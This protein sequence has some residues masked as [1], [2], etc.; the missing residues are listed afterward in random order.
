ME[1]KKKI[2]YQKQKTNQEYDKLREKIMECPI[3]GAY[4]LPI[5]CRIKG[6]F[7]KRYIYH[8]FCTKCDTKWDSEIK[9]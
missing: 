9:K 2:T 7:K 3:C 4:G 5:G 6:L 8:N 1:V